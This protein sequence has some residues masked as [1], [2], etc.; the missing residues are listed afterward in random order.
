M[1]YRVDV[2]AH[3]KK[4]AKRLIKKFPS[5]KSEISG[6]IA[7]L[8]QE[9]VQGNPLGNNCFKIRLAISSKG[10][11][12]SGGAGIISYVHFKGGKVFL[13]TIYDKSEQAD[14]SDDEI[15]SLIEGLED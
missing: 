9:P 2:T 8:E 3:F 4:Q 15:L 1:A 11:G 5:L 14:V 12:K 13:L 10:R 7:L 6:L